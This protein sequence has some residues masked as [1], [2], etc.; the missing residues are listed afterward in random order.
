MIKFQ[1]NFSNQ[2]A[3]NFLE[4]WFPSFSFL[5][6]W[7]F[8]QKSIWSFDSR[9]I[10]VRFQFD[11]RTAKNEK[12]GASSEI[13]SIFWGEFFFPGKKFWNLKWKFL[14]NFGV[15]ERKIDRKNK[16]KKFG[17]ILNFEDSGTVA[18]S[19]K[20]MFCFLFLV[21]FVVMA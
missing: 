19:G 21:S 7:K 5:K 14:E 12:K 13:S 9:M 11:S 4:I 6:N 17:W 2:F 10:S 3:W 20:F 8:F 15:L 18:F 1:E 16:G